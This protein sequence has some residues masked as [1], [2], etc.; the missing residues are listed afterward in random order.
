MNNYL[1]ALLNTS[2]QKMN[3]QTPL[4][5]Q[6]HDNS[7][8]RVETYSSS[9]HDILLSETNLTF[10]RFCFCQVQANDSTRQTFGTHSLQ[11]FAYVHMHGLAR[12]LISR[13]YKKS[14][15]KLCATGCT[16][17][18]HFHLHA[19]VMSAVEKTS[20]QAINTTDITALL[21]VCLTSV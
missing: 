12:I 5:C 16:T 18:S 20:K 9:K 6:S 21:S 8:K 14:K 13:Q 10:T 7:L 1:I 2:L 15:N 19:A 11:I 3:I 4:R 17:Q